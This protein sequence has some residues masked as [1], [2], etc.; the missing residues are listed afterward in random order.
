MNKKTAG[1]IMMGVGGLVAITML[2]LLFKWHPVH[3]GIIVAAVVVGYVGYLL[4]KKG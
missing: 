2:V 4:Y 3:I 1:M